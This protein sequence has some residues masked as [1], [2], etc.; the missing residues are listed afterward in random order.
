MSSR[1]M[2]RWV[3]LAT[4]AMAVMLATASVASAAP[5]VFD[6]GQFSVPNDS[7][8]DMDHGQISGFARADLNYAPGGN[9]RWLNPY[10]SRFVVFGASRPTFKQC[11]L[12]AVQDQAYDLTTMVGYWFCD[13]TNRS[14]VSRFKVLSA[15]DTRLALRFTTWT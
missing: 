1:S 3:V 6:S 7:F 8:F 11:K 4:L 10:N 13:H 15:T 12:A 9:G 5:V 2:G 14:R